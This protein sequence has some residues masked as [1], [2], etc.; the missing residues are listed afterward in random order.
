LLSELGGCIAPHLANLDATEVSRTYWRGLF[1][2]GYA[3]GVGAA[4]KRMGR[5]IL[6]AQRKFAVIALYDLR[7]L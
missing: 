4:V 1:A 3:S 2:I 5:I 6:A 7:G